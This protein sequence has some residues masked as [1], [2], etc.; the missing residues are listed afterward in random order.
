MAMARNESVARMVMF[1]CFG[2]AILSLAV[3][4]HSMR[5]T[6]QLNPSVSTTL[7]KNSTSPTDSSK[8]IS[9]GISIGETAFGA[10]FPSSPSN[11]TA[12]K[13]YVAS[14]ADTPKNTKLVFPEQIE[15]QKTNSKPKG[16]FF[17][18]VDESTSVQGSQST[19]TEVVVDLS[20]HRVYVYRYD[21]VIASYPIAIGKKGWETP[22]GSFQVIHKEHHPIWKHPITGKIYEAGTDS[23][24]GDRW[25]GFWSDGRNEIG[26]HGTPDTD[27]IGAAV[28][29]GCLRMRNPDVRMLY[30]QVDLGTPV[31][32]RD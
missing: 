29:H 1:L 24:L 4:W 11:S 7:R 16:F 19:Q 21:Q 32:V 26:F 23:P 20:D 18:G 12:G 15:K 14:A 13:K 2:T 30:E 27:L 28:S 25:I 10:S 17:R 31:L 8:N 9:P 5:T 6:A 22:T 3:H